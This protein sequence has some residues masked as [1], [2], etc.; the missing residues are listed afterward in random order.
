MPTEVPGVHTALAVV[1]AVA[2]ANEFQARMAQAVISG[3]VTVVVE[4]VEITQAVTQGQEVMED[5]QVA[6]EEA[7]VQVE[8][9]T[10]GQVA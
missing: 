5:R 2:Q 8:P 1:V 4:A 10:L 3:A 7:V 9:L 6:V